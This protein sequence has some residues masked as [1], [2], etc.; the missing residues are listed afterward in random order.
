M[1]PPSAKIGDC[2][3]WQGLQNPFQAARYHSLVIDKDSCPEDLEVTAWTEDGVIMGV[4]HKQFPHI[5]VRDS[6]AV[7]VTAWPP[8]D[9]VQVV[10]IVFMMKLSWPLI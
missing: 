5:Q 10:D 2:M 9:S 6:C 8:A 7:A 1:P 4:Q 3:G